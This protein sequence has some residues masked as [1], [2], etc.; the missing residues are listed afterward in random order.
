MSTFTKSGFRI[1]VAAGGLFALALCATPPLAA[2][3]SGSLSLHAAHTSVSV[4]KITVTAPRAGDLDYKL[5]AGDKLRI[6][7]YGEEDLSGEFQ[8]DGTGYVRL[9][10]IG[11][12]AAAGLSAHQIEMRVES[13]LDDGYLTH[14]R[15]AVEVMVYRPFSIIGEVNK[16]GEYPY[17]SN[18]TV[19][20]AI[21][22]AGGYTQK[23]M[24][25]T[26]YVRH[27]GEIDE[28]PVAADRPIRIFPGDVVRVPETTFWVTADIL[29]P[30]TAVL[31]PIT[32]LAYVLK[33]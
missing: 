24:A 10:L 26:M 29:S 15:V 23:A 2:Q 33:P 11:D 12:L 13:A 21:A 22:L 28:H 25:S 19:M 8:V 17:V 7:V 16:P 30:V 14:A 4:E 31:S 9:P 5:G 27:E 3:E 6:T 32:S 20:N 1:S 18:M